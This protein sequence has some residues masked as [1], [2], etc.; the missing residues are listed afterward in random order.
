VTAGQYSPTIE[1]GATFVRVVTC[2]DEAGTLLNLTGYSA[3]MQLREVPGST[4]L[5]SLTSPSGGIVLGGA[6]GTITIT[7]T[8]TQTRALIS[9]TAQ[10]V[11]YDLELTSPSG[12]VTRL[13]E[14]LVEV[15]PEVTA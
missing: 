13:L 15:R 8:A 5:I 14:G 9:H 11:H 10:L 3:A 2:R 4:P 12:V 1:Q 7:L 6:L